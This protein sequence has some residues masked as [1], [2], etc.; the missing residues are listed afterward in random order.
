[1]TG[2]AERVA[3][4]DLVTGIC[5][6]TVEPVDTEVVRVN[7]AASVPSI[8]SS[9]PPDLFGNGRGIFAEIFGCRLKGPALIEG[10]FYE[11]TVFK[12]KV[13]VVSRY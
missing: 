1:M 3:D 7:K 10:L 11:F 12:C 5:F 13:S 6:F 8:N 4:H 9:V 2:T